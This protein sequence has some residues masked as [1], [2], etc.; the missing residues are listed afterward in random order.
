MEDVFPYVL[1]GSC[2]LCRVCDV[3]VV[4][5][6]VLEM[7]CFWDSS[8]SPDEGPELPGVLY[9]VFFSSL[10]EGQPVFGVVL[11]QAAD[12]VVPQE[13]E[14]SADKGKSVVVGGKTVS[15]VEEKAFCSLRRAEGVSDSVTFLWYRVISSLCNRVLDESN[16]SVDV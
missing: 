9:A 12:D 13:S 16:L 7:C 5:C 3:Y 1:E 6:D 15:V 8:D 4:V 10:D 2:C 14:V 11:I